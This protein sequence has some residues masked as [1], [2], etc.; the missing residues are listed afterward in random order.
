MTTPLI[1]GTAGHVDHGK[2]TL[3]K[4]LTGIDPDRLREEQE[5]GMTIDLGF[6]WLDLPDV[7]RVGIVDVPG[8]E[9]FLKNMLAGAGGVDLALLVVAADEG[10]MPQTREHLDILSLLDVRGVVVAVT[11][12]DLA[13]ADMRVLVADEVVTMLEERGLPEPTTVEVSAVTGA[14]LDELKQALAD[15]LAKLPGRD[16][17]S[18]ARLPI[19]RVFTMQGFGTV[20]T[21]TLVAGTVREG[22]TLRLL[23]GATEVRVRGLQIHGEKESEAIAGQRV[24]VN[25]AGIAKDNL[26]RGQVVAQPGSC[27]ETTLADVVLRLLPDAPILKHQARVRVHIGTAEALARVALKEAELP[28][29]EEASAQLI[30]E[31]P[32]VCAR[33]DRFVLRRYSPARTIGGGTIVV[34][35]AKRRRRAQISQ[36]DSAAPDDA[37]RAAIAASPIGLRADE[38]AKATGISQVNLDD[39]PDIG[40]RH[41]TDETWRALSDRLLGAVAKFHAANP[42]HPAMKKATLIAESPLAKDPKAADAALERLAG[43][44]RLVVSGPKVKLPD[45]EVHLSD[46]QEALLKKIEELLLAEGIAIPTANGLPRLIGLPAPAVNEILRL[47]MT[48]DRIAKVSEELYYPVATINQVR[49][50]IRQGIQT[51]G[52]MTVASFRDLTGTSRKYAVPLLEYFDQIKFTRRVGDDRVLA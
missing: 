8:H 31:T 45:F 7:G 10:V 43:E 33:G 15:G 24:A 9:R 27:D 23:P 17:N 30:F 46:K 18:P 39:F 34:P 37:V 3:I 22:D 50:K 19:D 44:Q 16:A 48:V 20:V 28:S 40:G 35:L 2:S 49:E 4:A 25:L 6:A 47:G 12:S 41:Y 13:D 1:I 5:R 29:G 38:V 51:D 32:V 52:V 36:L 21:G 11:K 14:G 42:M 26:S